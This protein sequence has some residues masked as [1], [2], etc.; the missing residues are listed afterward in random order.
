MKDSDPS[1]MGKKI[2]VSLTIAPA[3]SKES[4]QAL[5]QGVKIQTEPSW[6]SFRHQG[7]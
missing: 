3:Y 4:F 6:L 2:E 5:V 1:E 7:R